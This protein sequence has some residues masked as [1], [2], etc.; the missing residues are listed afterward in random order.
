ME[1]IINDLDHVSSE[2]VASTSTV[3]SKISGHDKKVGIWR[4][5]C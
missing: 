3:D 2:S 1:R 4:C 5:M